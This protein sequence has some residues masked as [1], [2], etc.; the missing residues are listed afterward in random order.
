MQILA[1]PVVENKRCHTITLQAEDA[2]EAAY[3][4]A[5]LS[6]WRREPH[7]VNLA[8]HLQETLAVIG[9]MTENGEKVYI[10]Q[11]CDEMGLDS[12]TACNNRFAELYNLGLIDRVPAIVPEGGRRYLYSLKADVAA[13]AALA[14]R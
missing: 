7:I 12:V 8:P 13:E 4:F 3:L 6:R 9:R 1:E 2:V 5:T 11:V 10:H 14:A